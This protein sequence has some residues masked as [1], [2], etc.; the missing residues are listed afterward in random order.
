[1]FFIT[2]EVANFGDALLIDI[3]VQA[4]LR[5]DNGLSVME[6]TDSVMGY[7]VPPG[8]FAPFSLRFGQGQPALT[9]RF[10]LTLG[11]E[12]WESNPAAV[13]LGQDELTWADESS[14]TEDGDLLVSG[15]ITNVSA[16]SIRN[17]RAV[18]TVFDDAQNVIAAGFTDLTVPQ[19]APDET[20]P[21]QIRVPEMGGEPAHYIV[22]VQGRP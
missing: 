18:V 1:V 2:G 13:I 12:A 16:Q 21:F 4:V 7:G 22:N 17:L 11:N 8:S 19:L 3:P 6:A 10:E 5:T 15:T 9:T 14:F 20:S